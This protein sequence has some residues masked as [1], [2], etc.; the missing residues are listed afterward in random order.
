MAFNIRRHINRVQNI[1]R[2][3][4]LRRVNRFYRERVDPFQAYDT[5]F[6]RRYRFDKAESRFVIELVRDQLAPISERYNC[7]SP[8]VQVLT[9][10][11]FYAKGLYQEDHGKN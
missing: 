10:L 8:E 11:R 6:K 5:E 9:T 3:R 4:N 1:R 7:I 2:I